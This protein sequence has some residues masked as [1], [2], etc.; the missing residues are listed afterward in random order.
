MP[1]LFLDVEA[2]DNCPYSLQLVYSALGDPRPVRAV[3]LYLRG[4]E[5]VLFDVTGWEDGPVPAKGVV[6]EDSGQ[7]RAYLVHGGL[8]GLRFRGYESAGVWDLSDTSQWGESH[9]LISEVEDI[10]WADD[11]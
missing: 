6:V 5:G 11:S 7:G 10:V 2:G 1:T 4:P 8:G 9:L 3:K